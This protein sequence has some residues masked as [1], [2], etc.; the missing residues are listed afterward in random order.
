M[1]PDAWRLSG[2]VTLLCILLAACTTDSEP[3]SNIVEQ[4]SARIDAALAHL[5]TTGTANVEYSVWLGPAS[6]PAWYRHNAETVRPA[7]SAIKTALAIEFFADR[8]ESLDQAVSSIDTIVNDPDAAAIRHFDAEQKQA[9]RQDLPGLTARQLVEAM[10][11]KQHVNSNAAYNAAANVIIEYLGGPAAA[12]TRIHRRF[13]SAKDLVIARYMLADRNTNDDNLLTADALATVLQH[14][15]AGGAG[16][17]L[18]ATV[19]AAMLLDTGTST[20]EH[21]YKGGTLS[22]VPQVRIEAGWWE[23]QGQAAIYVVI[24]T[25]D[26]ADGGDAAF[27]KLKSELAELSSLVQEAGNHLSRSRHK[28]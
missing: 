28:E 19:R 22:S 21:Y 4:E 2:I 8:I 24:A 14:L 26:N 11:H 13:P 20:G 23:Q 10:L 3:Q 6:G 1:I 15:T 12:T 5:E 17:D 16:T 18:N 25:R 7:A 27:E 9:A